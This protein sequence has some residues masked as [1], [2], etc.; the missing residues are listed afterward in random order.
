MTGTAGRTPCEKR[1][2]ILPSNILKCCSFSLS[3][4]KNL[5][6]SCCCFAEDRKEMHQDSKR[7]CTAIVLFIKPFV[8]C[9]S[10]HRR[11]RGLLYMIELRNLVP[12]WYSRPGAR[13]GVNSRR[14][15]SRRLDILWWYR[16]NKCRAMRGNRSELTPARNSP[17]CHVNT[18]PLH[19]VSLNWTGQKT[20]AKCNTKCYNPPENDDLPQSRSQRPR[21]FW[22]A[23]GIATPGQVQLRKSAIYERPIVLRILRV[24]SDKSDWFWSQSIVFTQPFKTG[25]SLGLARGPDISSAWQKGSLGTRLDLPTMSHTPLLGYL[26][27]ACTCA[28]ISKLRFLDLILAHY[29]LNIKWVCAV[30][31]RKSRF[32]MVGNSFQH[33]SWGS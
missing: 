23:T 20:V 30:A 25:M 13:T 31:K 15:D 5:I 16:V 12:G 27:I 3:N 29:H 33:K 17:R 4:T 14:G 18:P 24:K 11:L 7:T 9:R 8:W 28:D 32:K 10:R 19:T 21:S 2:Y 1:I 6:I 26:F 22:L